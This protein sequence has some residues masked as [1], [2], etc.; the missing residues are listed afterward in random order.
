MPSWD[1]VVVDGPNLY[2]FVVRTL[3]KLDRGGLPSYVKYWLDFD[4]LLAASCEKYEPILGTV[5]FHSGKQ[6]GSARQANN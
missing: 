5:I 4:R 1:L 3:D 2:N 6:L